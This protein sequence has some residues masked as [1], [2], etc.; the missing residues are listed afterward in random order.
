[1]DGGA[2]DGADDPRIEPAAIEAFGKAI[3]ARTVIFPATGHQL[4]FDA[5][6]AEI[7][8]FLKDKLGITISR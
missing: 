5:R 7:G 8:P 4:G 3:G 1:V 6:N 2:A